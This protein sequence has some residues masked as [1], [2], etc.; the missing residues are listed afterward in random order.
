MTIP[1]RTRRV[2][3]R[4][5]TIL[6]TLS[7]VAVFVL[8][9]WLL[10]L[11]RFLVYTKDGAYLDFSQDNKLMF[12]ELATP[13]EPRPTV[14]IH[15]GDDDAE[16]ST[17]LTQLSGF[18][19]TEADLSAPTSSRTPMDD[20]AI[21]IDWLIAQ[22]KKLPAGTPVMLEIKNI[23]GR[24]FYNSA[25]STQR[26]PQINAEKLDELIS[27]LSSQGVYL[28]AQLPAFRDY[29]FGL[30]HVPAGIH[31]SSGGY[32]WMDDKGCYW[33]NPNHQNT[34]T[35]LAQ[36]LSELKLLGFDEAVFSDFSIPQSEN[37]LFTADKEASIATAAKTLV[38]ACSTDIFAVSFMGEPGFPLP[39]GRSRLY[40][41]NVSGADC[42]AVASQTGLTT[43]DTHLVFIAPSMDTRYDKYGVL[44]PLDGVS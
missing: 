31:H 8:M 18:Y 7:L 35:Y 13:T 24:F 1:Y 40:I 41:S 42:D 23:R 15:F 4:L 43:P 44:R 6:L 30:N 12:G 29:Y 33:L 21:K 20:S 22:V 36:I 38:L 37:I 17:Q 9:C 14:A 10:W 3:K 16:V 19:I 28:I 25:I 11:D 5:C 32:L 27:V 2:L 26:S 34:I 39:E